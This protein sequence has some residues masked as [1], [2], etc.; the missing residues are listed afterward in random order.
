[1]NILVIED[2]MNFMASMEASLQRRG[3]RVFTAKEG[4][5]AVN[6]MNGNNV[7]LVLTDGEYTGNT[8]FAEW[9]KDNRPEI[10]M[11]VLSG[12]KEEYI[13]RVF[14]VYNKFFKKGSS[15]NPEELFNCM[16]DILG[17]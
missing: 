10:P 7:D 4:A 16:K 12:G 9:K 1:M 8:V 3:Y 15:F 2:D 14:P 13:N 11:I 6:I 17:E 5:Y